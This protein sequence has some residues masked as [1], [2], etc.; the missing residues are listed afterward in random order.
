MASITLHR[1]PWIVPVSGPA[2]AD[3]IVAA[4]PDRIVEVGTAADL[5]DKYPGTG[6]VVHDSC[7]LL[8]ALI[9]AHIH[10]ELSHLPIASQQESVSGFTDWIGIL[11]DA[12]AQ[13]SA[14][15]GDR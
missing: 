7:V 6:T 12:R 8:P 5:Q 1:A 2:I 13:Q 10:L 15:G 14:T 9:N 3:G 11:L 4:D